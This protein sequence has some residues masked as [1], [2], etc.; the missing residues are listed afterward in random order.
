ME[1][2]YVS[3]HKNVALEYKKHPEYKKPSLHTARHI[4]AV[5]ATHA[6]NATLATNTA[7]SAVKKQLN[8]IS[9][10]VA[11]KDFENKLKEMKHRIDVTNDEINNLYHKI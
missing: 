1:K 5:F 7:V 6:I 11:I 8:N 9:N 2:R 3:E 10:N 4:D